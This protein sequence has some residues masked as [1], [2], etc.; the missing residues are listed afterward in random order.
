MGENINKHTHVVKDSP[1]FIPHQFNDQNKLNICHQRNKY[2]KSVVHVNYACSKGKGS[3]CL[4]HCWLTK[5][6]I[7]PTKMI[8]TLRVLELGND[9]GVL[10]M[11]LLVT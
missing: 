5:Y 3:F 6:G 4:F 9:D 1:G 8:R 10:N 7:E 2:K 11:R